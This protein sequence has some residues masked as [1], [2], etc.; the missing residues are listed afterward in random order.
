MIRAELVSSMTSFLRLLQLAPYS[1]DISLPNCDADALLEHALTLNKFELTG[2]NY[3]QLVRIK[4]TEK[5]LL[6]YYRNNVFHL[7]VVPSLVSIIVINQK[8]IKQTDL[9]KQVKS[10]Y[11]LL[12]QELFMQAYSD[13]YVQQTLKGLASI[14]LI[15]IESGVI[16]SNPN[17]PAKAQLVNLS[18]MIEC[19]LIRYACVL[20][21]ILKNDTISQQELESESQLFAGQLGEL[22][23]INTPEFFDQKILSS[24]IL[25]LK[26]NALIADCNEGLITSNEATLELSN[27]IISY[28]KPGVASALSSAIVHH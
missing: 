10:L 16:S 3:T 11:P 14:G 25:S 23:D 28:L 1:P 2:Q 5:V 19:T 9:V 27:L 21:L 20:K 6:N 12:K 22:F 24:L 8:K 18:K 15:T 13:D 7:F 26:Q 4:A 17:T